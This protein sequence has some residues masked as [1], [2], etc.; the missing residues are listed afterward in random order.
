MALGEGEQVGRM[1]RRGRRVREE[2]IAPHEA[3]ALVPA[4]DAPELTIF[5]R[6][7]RSASCHAGKRSAA[8]SDNP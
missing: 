6:R 7:P 1:G 2:G 8:G 5:L 4:G 3:F